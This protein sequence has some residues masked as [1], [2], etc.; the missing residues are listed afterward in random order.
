ME[1]SLA[2]KTASLSVGDFASFTL[3]PQSAVGGPQG[4]ERAQLGQQWHQT[5]RRQVEQEFTID[6]TLH[7]DV[8]FETAI[9][10]Q[11]V[12]R[13]WTFLLAGRI[14][15]IIGRTL[16]EIKSV[17]QRLPADEATL[18]ADYPSYFRQ[19]AAYLVLA[20]MTA[21]PLNPLKTALVNPL[22]RPTQPAP[23][24]AELIFVETSS[25]LTQTI[26]LTPFDEALIYHQL[27]ALVEFLNLRARATV[28]RA[29]AS[30]AQICTA[31]SALARAE[32][33]YGDAK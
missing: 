32:W 21:L 18:R 25:G 8:Q 31:I 30:F 9:S 6:G 14:D 29:A 4:I 13:G 24:R 10:G 26:A 23:L 11:L 33:P 16:R 2:Q 17:T 7:A 15:Q 19:L 20:R 12:H 27:D 28:P 3:G 22:D 5:L 1:F